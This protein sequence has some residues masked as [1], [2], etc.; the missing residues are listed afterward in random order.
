MHRAT[1]EWRGE[2]KF[3][4]SILNISNAINEIDSEDIEGGIKFT[5]TASSVE[6]LRKEVDS[7]LAECAIIE[8]S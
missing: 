3:R 4:Q 2:V 6:N 1:I 8:Q 5:I 7:F